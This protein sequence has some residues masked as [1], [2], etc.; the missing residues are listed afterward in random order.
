VVTI[1]DAGVLFAG[2]LVEA[3][4]FAIFPWFPPYT[5]ECRGCAGSR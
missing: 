1:P 2:D 5:T 4:E 3:G